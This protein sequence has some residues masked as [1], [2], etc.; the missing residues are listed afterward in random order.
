MA[1]IAFRHMTGDGLGSLAGL[2]R[3]LEIPFEYLDVVHAD[4]S[5]FDPLGPELLVVLGGSPGVYQADI[6]PFLKEELR[7]IK[8]RLAADKP[9]LGICLG[10][11]LMAGAL[12]AKVYPGPQGA[13]KGW[14]P[15]SLTEAGA[16]SPVAHLAGE[17]TSML[18]WHGDTFDFPEGA[19]LLASSEKYKHQAFG[20]GRNCIGLQCHPE[21][22]PRHIEEWLV[23]GAGSVAQGQLDI[24]KVRAETAQHGER[25][26]EQTAQFMLEYLTH[27]GLVTAEQRKHA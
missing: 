1:V 9:T 7:I 5:D 25:L 14:F 27:I 13:E 21:M 16:Q 3:R 17:K 2:F 18:H 8:A 26:V 10:S 19:V 6:Y 15:L 24:H 4:L 12:G 11:Q 20:V 23:S 22:T